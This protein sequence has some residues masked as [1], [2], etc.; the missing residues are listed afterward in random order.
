MSKINMKKLEKITID[1]DKYV[2]NL[3]QKPAEAKAY[4]K[5]IF[6]GYEEDGDLQAF[7]IGLNRLARAKGSLAQLAE[8]TDLNRQNLYKIF[9]GKSAPR[10]D[11][12]SVLLHGLGLQLSVEPRKTKRH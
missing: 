3:L 12:L 8:K 7:L 6:E 5:A 4:A 10:V 11:T 9:S 2:N 1:Y